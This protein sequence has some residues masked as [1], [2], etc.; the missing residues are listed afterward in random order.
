MIEEEMRE[1]TIGDPLPV[2]KDEMGIETSKT[3][4]TTV[5]EF[6]TR[7]I[8]ET[9]MKREEMTGIQAIDEI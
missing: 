4:D 3:H 8:K 1:E 9:I 2:T 6:L 7:E 5:K